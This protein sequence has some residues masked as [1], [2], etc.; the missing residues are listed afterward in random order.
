MSDA[1]PVTPL[2]EASISMI[3]RLGAADWQLRYQDDEQPVV[4][5]ALASFERDG[6]VVHEVAAALN[7]ERAAFR[8]L[9]LLVD[10][11]Q[12]Q[13]CQRPTGV[14][15]DFAGEMLADELV[16]WYRFD[17]ELK[18]FRRGCE[19]DVPRG[20]SRP[21]KDCGKSKA[22]HLKK[23]QGHAYRPDKRIRP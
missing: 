2:M 12:C 3:G 8:L 22:E 17:P 7:P 6:G 4:W 11:G 1:P 20:D 9:E 15:D 13:H 16:C 5:M 23:Y 19:G 14:T 21:C 18:T 10:G